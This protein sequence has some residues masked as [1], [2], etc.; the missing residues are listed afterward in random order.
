M[1]PA[2]LL[3][4]VLVMSVVLTSC[5][6]V[7]YRSPDLAKDAALH[8]KVAVL[9]FTMILTGKQP[10]R[11][12]PNQIAEIEEYESLGFQTSLYYAM[13]NRA[14]AG[15][16]HRI[17][18]EL[19]AVEDTNDILW[20]S[21]ISIRDSWVMD[22]NV[23]AEI[24]GVDAVIRTEVVKTRYLSNAA[25]F[26]FDL[27][28]SVVNEVS[29]GKLGWFIPW[30]LAKTHDIQADAALLDGGDGELLWKV[31]VHRETDWTREAN[32]VIEG[33]TRKLARKFPYQS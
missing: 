24:L 26:G 33:V 19:Q 4:L 2:K 32:D 25:S 11:L 1:K 18:I 12:T 28:A 22:A 17:T 20:E 6:S 21:G 14:D 16:K 29:D 5:V 31:A 3:L 9:P 7:H 15:R 13:L 8:Q 27:G 30:G 23:L 10:A